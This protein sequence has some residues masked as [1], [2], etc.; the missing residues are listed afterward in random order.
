MSAARRH[1]RGEDGFTLVELL[2]SIAILAI[3]AVPLSMGFI[4]GLRFIGRSDEKFNDSRSSLISAGYFAGD[5]ANANTIVPNDATACGGGTALVSLDWSDASG[6]VGGAVNNEVSYVYDTSD[7]TNKQLL[8]KYCANGSSTA[9]QSVAAV[10]LGSSPV[11]TCYDAGNV[12]NATC[13]GARWVKMVVTQKA[14][15]ASPDNPTPVAYTF[16][17]EGTRRPL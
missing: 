14:N 16:T 17:L 10:S 1:R 11:V 8:R 5:V 12:V 7:A 4:T 2:I 3:I 15:T 9:T 13:A 6:G